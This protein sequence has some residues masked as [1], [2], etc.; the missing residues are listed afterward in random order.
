MSPLQLAV[1]RKLA[2]AHRILWSA[3]QTA[4]SSVDQHLADDL[5][6]LTQ[7]VGRLQISLLKT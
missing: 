4:E 1:E 7:E 5:Y 3:A 2:V 6:Q